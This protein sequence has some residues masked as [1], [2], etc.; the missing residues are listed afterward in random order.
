MINRENINSTFNRI[1]GAL[2]LRFRKKGTLFISK[3][4]AELARQSIYNGEYQNFFALGTKV[5]MP[6]LM[7]VILKS[8]WLVDE[9]ALKDRE[10]KKQL[11]S[12]LN[13][14]SGDKQYINLLRRI[15]EDDVFSSM[16][17]KKY[18]EEKYYS[19]IDV[20]DCQE[21]YDDLRIKPAIRALCFARTLLASSEDG[22]SKIRQI[23]Q[24]FTF[25]PDVYKEVKDKTFLNDIVQQMSQKNEVAEWILENQLSGKV[26][27]VWSSAF[28]A[29]RDDAFTATVDY[30]NENMD[31]GDPSTK[32]LIRKVIPRLFLYAKD[33]ETLMNAYEEKVVGLYRSR[34]A[35]R[36]KVLFLDMLEP[37]KFKN[38]ELAHR[39]LDQFEN[40]GIHEKFDN[41][42][43]DIRNWEDSSTGYS[44]VDDAYMNIS[45]GQDLTRKGTLNFIAM[46]FKKTDPS[47]IGKL[48][49]TYTNDNNIIKA[50]SYFFAKQMMGN[51]QQFL[52][53][54]NSLSQDYTDQIIE[55]IDEYSIDNKVSHAFLNQNGRYDILEKFTRR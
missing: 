34:E 49:E 16:T 7:Q 41:R 3:G 32:M 10:F 8:P 26:D 31:Y 28:M 48:Y 42:V 51:G 39:L 30:I 1:E 23:D 33:D 43:A 14:E 46:Q 20:D 6:V 4:D 38:K 47:V 35:Y 5:G 21:I 40:I 50:L 54:L 52:N 27:T 12:I 36:I 11:N 24:M 2:D 19:K 25:Q 55:Y 29:L 53:K 18:C 15:V 37:S 9:R 22:P 17:F 45:I 44:T 13:D